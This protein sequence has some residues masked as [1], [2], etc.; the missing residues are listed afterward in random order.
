MKKVV[1][2]LGVLFPFSAGSMVASSEIWA[3]GVTRASGWYDVNKRSTVS[4]SG[5]DRN[6]CWAAAASNMLQWWFDRYEDAGQVIPSNLSVGKGTKYTCSIFEDYFL[7]NWDPNHG[8]S[9]YDGLCWFFEGKAPYVTTG[10][11]KPTGG[12]NYFSSH[13]E[14]LTAMDS[15]YGDYQERWRPLNNNIDNYTAVLTE[16]Y[17]VCLGGSYY[18]WGPGRPDKSYSSGQFFANYLTTMLKY[19]PAGLGFAISANGN[20]KNHEITVWG[21]VVDESGL[22]SKIFVSDSD[23]AQGDPLKT[24]LKEYVVSYTGNYVAIDYNEAKLDGG[25]YITSLTGIMGYPIPEPS[26][27]GLFAGAIAFMLAGTRRSRRQK[28]IR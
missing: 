21:C 19:G 4:V 6:A 9:S 7:L 14:V 24:V 16:D 27:F 1:F 25:N 5:I 2:A 22:V 26:S 10:Y 18:T 17:A 23:D 11:S 15:A 13:P 20:G 8:A 28:E 12:G 3:P